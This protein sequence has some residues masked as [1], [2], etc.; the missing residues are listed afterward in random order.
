MAITLLDDN[1][2]NQIA[3][4]EVVDRPASIV[5]ELMENSI[6]A[7]A[8]RIIVKVSQAGLEK[9]VVEDN[10]VGMSAEDIPMAF[11][12]HA[13]SK[14]AVEEDLYR[15]STMGF[16][17]EALP[18]IASVSRVEI[19]SKRDDDNGVYGYLEAGEI[20]KLEPHAFPRGTR[21]VVS[22]LFFNTPARRKFLRSSV[23]E[24]RNIYDAVA[25]YALA[26]PDIS[27]TYITDKKVFFKTPGHGN[28][29]EVLLTIYGKE[30]TQYLKEISYEGNDYC[31]SGLIS[32]PEVSRRNR[33]NQLL[34]VNNRPVKSPVFYKAID[35]AYRGL[36]VSQEKPLAFISLKVPPD[37][38]DVNVH[39]QKLEIR[40]KDEKAVFSVISEAC[41]KILRNMDFR[42][43][44]DNYQEDISNA[45]YLVYNNTDVPYSQ[46]STQLNFSYT[47]GEKGL[48]TGDTFNN[49]IS[50]DTYKIEENISGEIKVVGQIF[51]SYIIYESNDDLCLIDQHAAHERI[52]Y[53]QL[54]KAADSS[55]NIAQVLA[56][57][58]SLNISS[59]HAELLE[60]NKGILEQLGFDI[61]LM[62]ENSIIIRSAPAFIVGY[63]L[64]TINGII[65]LLE[66]Q[67]VP[68]LKDK[69]IIMMACKKAIK[70]NTRLNF[71]EME[72]II[73]DLYK[74]DNYTK[75]PH[76]RPTIVKLGK[77]ELERMFK[78]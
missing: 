21:I 55:E 29:K 37:G 8:N 34:F 67:H 32:S 6:D 11:L 50:S 24:G 47:Q 52:V 53:E 41:S 76:G 42:F 61:S 27:F 71:L 58:L 57:P 51:N 65:E 22:D 64:E 3:A 59:R 66:E 74:V 36:L 18:S 78:R 31:L 69:A 68:D 70:A 38:V 16:R 73:N 30:F 13:T 15:I 77:N 35:T 54:K 75:C 48:E 23:S 44:P 4:G 72:T 12:R 40:F 60:N 39:P 45:N 63:E 25:R 2:I 10:G 56:F 5:K 7:G 28:L 49:P 33:K 20:K 14:I 19:F 9:I 1:L 17:G 62:G 43:K 46:K 26:R